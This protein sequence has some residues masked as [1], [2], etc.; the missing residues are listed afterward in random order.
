MPGLDIPYELIIALHWEIQKT[1]TAIS[2]TTFSTQKSLTLAKSVSLL[3]C[4]SYFFFF[5]NGSSASGTNCED[6]ELFEN[7]PELMS[8][9]SSGGSNN[10]I[11][12]FNSLHLQ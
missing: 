9:E 2:S 8:L 1:L 6:D 11:T 7:S 5:A 3:C 10:A 4:F 12:R